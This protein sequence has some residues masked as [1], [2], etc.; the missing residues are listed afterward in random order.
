MITI[1]AE[2]QFY[3]DRRSTIP[4]ALKLVITYAFDIRK[5]IPSIKSPAYPYDNWRYDTESKEW[6][7][8]IKTRK[9]YESI[10]PILRIMVSVPDNDNLFKDDRAGWVDTHAKVKMTIWNDEEDGD[11]FV[12]CGDTYFFRD[13]IKEH[14][15]QWDPNEKCWENIAGA[16][17]GLIIRTVSW[18]GF[19]LYCT[20]NCDHRFAVLLA[21]EAYQ[22]VATHPAVINGITLGL[23]EQYYRCTR[24]DGVGQ[25][26]PDAPPPAA[27]VVHDF[28]NPHANNNLS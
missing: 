9:Q 26:A 18:W 24:F 7:T 14:A 2:P 19:D 11:F 20:F 16:S 10:L 15:D 6:H 3:A 12:M 8:M 23:D 25:P 4:W 1:R 17:G 5:K 13:L 21:E 22:L 27:E 28:S